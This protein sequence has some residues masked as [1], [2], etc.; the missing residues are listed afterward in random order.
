MAIIT[1]K[2]AFGWY[3][4]HENPCEDFNLPTKLG[5]YNFQVTVQATNISTETFTPELVILT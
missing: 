4:S 2:Y 5:T 1:T 3:G